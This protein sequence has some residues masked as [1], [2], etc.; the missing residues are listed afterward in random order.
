MWLDWKPEGR[1][2]MTLTKL[3]RRSYLW[4]KREGARHTALKVVEERNIQDI[5]TDKKKLELKVSI[6]QQMLKQLMHK[7][8]QREAFNK[9]IVGFVQEDLDVDNSHEKAED[10]SAYLEPVDYN[11]SQETIDFIESKMARSQEHHVGAGQDKD[12][13]GPPRSYPR[14]KDR[15]DMRVEYLAKERDAEKNNYGNKPDFPL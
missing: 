8:D 7:I 11:G 5:E 13:D 9:E 2:R 1:L 12:G 15:E 6:Q 3:S 10:G 4:S 14:L